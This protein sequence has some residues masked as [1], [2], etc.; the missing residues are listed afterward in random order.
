M[1]RYP[2]F[3]VGSF[4]SFLPRTAD[5]QKT[6]KRRIGRLRLLWT[7]GHIARA[8]AHAIVYLARLRVL[9]L[10]GGVAI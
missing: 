1:I 9:K 5:K 4:F 6:D 10:R 2:R 3:D 7:R 8:H